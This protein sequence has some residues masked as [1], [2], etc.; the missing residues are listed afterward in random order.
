MLKPN[1]T[2]MNKL[3]DVMGMVMNIQHFSIHDGPGIRTT[4]F[5]KG[6]PLH[7]A[8]CHNPESQQTNTEQ[9]V[10]LQRCISC[11][12][13]VRQC[14]YGGAV[15]EKGKVKI[16]PALCRNCQDMNSCSELCMSGARVLYGEPMTVESVIN[17]VLKDRDF[18]G[19][20][21][22][23]TISGGEPLA[24]GDFSFA[25]LKAAKETGINTAIE[26]AL[27]TPFTILEMMLDKLDLVLADIKFLDP[28]NSIKFTGINVDLVMENLR[29]LS[30][31]G[32]A[33]ILRMPLVFGLNDTEQEIQLRKNF[34]KELENVI[35]IDCFA[36]SNHGQN[37]YEALGQSFLPFNKDIEDSE[38]R[39]RE[40]ERRLKE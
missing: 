22:G 32:K 3:Y 19:S 14:K 31:A 10:Y 4:V 8:W 6:C 15:F 11:G 26:T 1:I 21:G 7:C 24:Q 17:E 33:V 28:D 29:G 40:F 30:D 5:L 2:D 23:I 36:V 38:Q 20:E 39:V 27:S 18:Y 37:K 34:L 35:R 12:G 9:M 25:V 13:C 16:S